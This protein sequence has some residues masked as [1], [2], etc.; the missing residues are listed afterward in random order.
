MAKKRVPKRVEGAL[1][2]YTTLCFGGKKYCIKRKELGRDANKGLW[3]FTNATL[4]KEC[5]LLMKLLKVNISPRI[6]DTMTAV[7][8]VTVPSYVVVIV[9]RQ[10]NRA[11]NLISII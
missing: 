4:R 1:I 9:P 7:L 3:Y 2:Y 11:C 8:L 10:T 6:E 5:S